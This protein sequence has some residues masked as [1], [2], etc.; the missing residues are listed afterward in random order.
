MAGLEAPAYKP[1]ARPVPWYDVG[2]NPGFPVVKASTQDA[3]ATLRLCRRSSRFQ[4]ELEL[5]G[6]A[7]S[8]ISL[9]GKPRFAGSK[10]MDGLKFRWLRC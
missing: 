9:S 6:Q 7:F 1:A 5:I 2:G 4:R 8:L 3:C 10:K